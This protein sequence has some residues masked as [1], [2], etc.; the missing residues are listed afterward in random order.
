MLKSQSKWLVLAF[1]E[2]SLIWLLQTTEIVHHYLSQID[3][4]MVAI[5][6]V[7]FFWFVYKHIKRE[8]QSDTNYYFLSPAH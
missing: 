4:V 8:N 5:L 2:A 6:A 1:K 3:V 7:V